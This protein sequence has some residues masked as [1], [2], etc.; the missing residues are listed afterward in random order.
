MNA[1]A[2]NYEL[3]SAIYRMM[4]EYKNPLCPDISSSVQVVKQIYAKAAEH[5]LVYAFDQKAVHNQIIKEMK[6]DIGDSE[7]LKVI[8][9]MDIFPFVARGFEVNWVKSLGDDVYRAWALATMKDIDFADKK[10]PRFMLNSLKKCMTYAVEHNDGEVI[11]EALQLIEWA[12][13]EIRIRFAGI[14]AFMSEL[15]QVLSIRGER[16]SVDIALADFLSELSCHQFEDSGVAVMGLNHLEQLNALE[17]KESAKV[18]Y[19]HYSPIP[20]NTRQ[21]CRLKEMFGRDY[22]DGLLKRLVEYD[23]DCI[24]LEQANAFVF[25]KLTEGHTT[26]YSEILTNLSNK[27]DAIYQSILIDVLKEQKRLSPAF[28]AFFT[29]LIQLAS[30]EQLLIATVVNHGWGDK[31]SQR[32]KDSPKLRKYILGHEMGL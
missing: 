26:G 29:D 6:I 31:L 3:S 32:M 1:I 28:M 13:D 22:V 10:D 30:N 7:S 12:F 9:L 27:F 24:R 18:I 15:I 14:D 23:T 5:S 20:S 25:Y 8:Q 4:G 21:L 2:I 19:E 16:S 11:T 17:Y